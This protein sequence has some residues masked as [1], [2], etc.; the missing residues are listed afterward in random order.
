MTNTEIK[1][2]ELKNELDNLTKKVL[3]EELI[4]SIEKKAE[5]RDN[6]VKTEVVSL[7]EKLADLKLKI[8][9]LKARIIYMHM[10]AVSLREN[11]Y[12]EPTRFPDCNLKL[13]LCHNKYESTL[14]LNIIVS[15]ACLSEGYVIVRAEDNEYD[16][17]TV[18]SMTIDA[19]KRGVWDRGL[20][21]SEKIG[22]LKL[23]IDLMSEYLRDFDKFERFFYKY[24]QNV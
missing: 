7:M 20:T 16:D 12:K 13:E 11:G 5:I 8:E 6:A 9:D 4:K 22:Y 3:A 14:E 24:A 17:V 15:R 19:I 18:R 1:I 10:I 21:D 23:D 2:R